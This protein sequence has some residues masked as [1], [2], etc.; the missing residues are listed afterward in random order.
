MSIVCVMYRLTSFLSPEV[1]ISAISSRDI[2]PSC[3]GRSAA[4]RPTLSLPIRM[5]AML[6]LKI[7]EVNIG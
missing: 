7:R 4:R 5:G 6:A 3:F 1:F 2:K